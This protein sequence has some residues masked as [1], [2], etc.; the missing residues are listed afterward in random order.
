M[1]GHNRLNDTEE[2][3]LSI[4]SCS[5]KEKKDKQLRRAEQERENEGAELDAAEEKRKKN[6]S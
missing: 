2:E 3:I 4:L 6:R 5:S 1:N